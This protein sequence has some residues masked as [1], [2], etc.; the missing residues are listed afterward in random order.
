MLNKP[1]SFKGAVGNFKIAATLEKNKIT[2]EDAGSLKVI[3]SGSGN[4]Q[5][6]NAPGIL[7]P[8]GIEGFESKASENIDKLSVPL[9]GDKVFIYPFTVN[10]AGKNY[11][12]NYLF[13]F[14]YQYSIL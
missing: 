10:S 4:I 11:P 2:T 5:L 9:M 3:I 7:W 14:R 8:E 13:L 6:V 12:S 1:P